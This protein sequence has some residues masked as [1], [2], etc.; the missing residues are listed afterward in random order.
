MPLAGCESWWTLDAIVARRA[1]ARAGAL[2]A[3]PRRRRLDGDACRCH[4]SI[5]TGSATAPSPSSR[6][7]GSDDHAGVQPRDRRA[8]GAARRRSARSR[9][10]R[11]APE[12]PTPTRSTRCSP[13][14]ERARSRDPHPKLAEA[15][16]PLRR[17]IIGIRLAK[18]GYLMPGWIGEGRFTLH[19]Y[20]GGDDDQLVRCRPSTSC[21][22]CSG[23]STS[24]R[25][26]ATCGRPR[27][28]RGRRPQP[29]GCAAA[30]RPAV[31]GP[32]ARAA[33]RRGRARVPGLVAGELAL[34]AGAG[35]AG[36]DHAGGRR[37]RRRAVVGPAARGRQRRSCARSRLSARC[38]RSATCCPITNLV[39][40]SAPRLPLEDTPVLGGPVEW[41]ADVLG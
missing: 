4:G 29:R 20:R 13:P 28:G 39:A 33:R 37:H 1:V 11:R 31:G 30:R 23:C 5:S 19:V 38:S 35:R 6:H 27:R 34:A 21:T 36:Q 9:R 41:V 14:P 15:L 25:A 32:A 10:S 26:R 2:D 8:D 22:S 18:T 3:R 16:V 17:P 24:A 12:R 7:C 40:Q